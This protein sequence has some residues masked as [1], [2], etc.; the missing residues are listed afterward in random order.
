M[1]GPVFRQVRHAPENRPSPFSGDCMPS[2]WKRFHRY[3]LFSLP[4][5]CVATSA[6]MVY[7]VAAVERP[8]P[9]FDKIE[10]ERGVAQA[11]SAPSPQEAPGGRAHKG[12]HPGAATRQ[13]SGP[14]Q[15][16]HFSSG[17]FR[18]SDALWQQGLSHTALARK[19]APSRKPVSTAGIPEGRSM[20]TQQA[21][22]AALEATGSVPAPL[23]MPVGKK[24][25]VRGSVS[26]Q[27]TAWRNPVTEPVRVGQEVIME[28]KNVMG[29]YADIDAGDGVIISAGPE[30]IMPAEQVMEQAGSRHN[31]PNCLGVGFQ[32]Q[33]AF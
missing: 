21:I 13:F 12:K 27:V 26:N 31:E 17:S 24:M 8:L 7:D 9:S 2:F 23:H 22:D 10:I 19:A 4:L 1:N 16:W 14:A 30:Y 33:W 28:S 15:P 32:L 6:A 11:P 3:W 18:N 29:A 20:D 5:L 25:A